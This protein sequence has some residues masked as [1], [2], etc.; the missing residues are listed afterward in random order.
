ME[1]E[2]IRI[3]LDG[4]NCYLGKSGDSFILFDTGGAVEMVK[5]EGHLQCFL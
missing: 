1:Q 4:V 3:D 2:I 5:R